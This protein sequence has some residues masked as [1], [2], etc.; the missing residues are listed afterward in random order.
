METMGK[1]LS[2]LFFPPPSFLQIPQ[3]TFKISGSS[4]SIPTETRIPNSPFSQGSQGSQGSMDGKT[5]RQE[6]GL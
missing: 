5:W 3:R 2:T 4:R 1:T 6:I